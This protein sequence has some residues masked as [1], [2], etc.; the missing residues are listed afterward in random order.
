M[1]RFARLPEDQ[2]NRLLSSL[3][4]HQKAALAYRWDDWLARPDQLPPRSDWRFW[5]IMAG[6]GFG[7]TRIGAEEL[8]KAAQ[9]IRFPNIIGAT[10]DDARDIMIEGESGILVICPPWERPVYQPSKRQLAW[11]NG[12]KTLIFTADEPERLRGKQHEWLWA[13]EMAAWRYPDAWDQAMFGLRLGPN[14]QAVVTTTPKPT[15]LVRDLVANEHCVVTR[16]STYDNLENL[17]EAFADEIIRK[18][19]GTRLGRQELMGELLEDEGLAYRFSDRLHVIPAFD[20]PDA[21]ERFE[22]MDYGSSNPTAW[23]VT[24]VDY[25]GNLIVADGLYEPG[26]PS[27]IAPKILERRKNG[28]QPEGQRNLVY[29]DPSI[30]NTTGTTNRWGQPASTA[31]EFT[32]DMGIPLIRANND[33]RAGYIRISELLRPNPERRF[34]AWHPLAGEPGCPRLFIMDVPG[35]VEL[36]EQLAQ[37]PLEEPI[38]SALSGPYPGEAVAVK[39]EGPKGHAHAS[40]R[41]G[42]LSR[43]APSEEPDQ[44]LDDPR[45]ELLRQYMK[46]RD[47]NDRARLNY[48]LV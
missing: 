19:Q 34:P 42:V 8:R 36:R 10:A 20:I 44:P 9:R 40:L 7:K 46:R 32:T 43:P 13:D 1:Q 6:R 22:H 18:Y 47:D 48:E 15:P 12:A 28:W 33:R 29:A 26:L 17:A 5:L 41:Y 3:S 4:D 45:A 16:G 31:D 21:W 14:P 37:A 25:D 38:G 39:W 2:R 23:F 11:P 30:W 27:E 24:A 35:T